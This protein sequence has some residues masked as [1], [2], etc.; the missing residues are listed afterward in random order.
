MLWFAADTLRGATVRGASR[1]I[2][3]DSSESRAARV[4]HS[5][6]VVVCGKDAI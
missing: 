3:V 6:G 1:R 2:A 5:P 4:H